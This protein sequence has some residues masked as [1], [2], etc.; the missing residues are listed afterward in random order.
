MGDMKKCCVNNCKTDTKLLKKCKS[1]A[2][3]ALFRPLKRIRNNGLHVLKI[4]NFPI[5]S[6]ANASLP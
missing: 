1:Q 2:F 4:S 6:P 3:D 5:C